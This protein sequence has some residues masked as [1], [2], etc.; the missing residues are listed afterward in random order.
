MTLTTLMKLLQL[1]TLLNLAILSQLFL[2]VG[3]GLFS[4]I[5]FHKWSPIDESPH[6]SYV[7]IISDQKRLPIMGI[8]TDKYDLRYPVLNNQPLS[9]IVGKSSYEAWQPPLYYLLVSPVFV[10]ATH[11]TNKITH[12]IIILRT[13]SL[14][15]YLLSALTFILLIRTLY[16]EEKWR[17]VAF[18]G[19]NVFLIQPMIV[20]NTTVSNCV[21]ELFVMVLIGL[22]YVLHRKV[23]SRKFL[24]AMSMLVGLGLL[25]KLTLAY[26]GI[27]LFIYL[28]FCVSKKQ[29]TLVAAVG[30][31][32]IP[33]LIVAPWIVFNYYHYGLATSG[34]LPTKLLLSITNPTGYNYTYKGDFFPLFN[35][36]LATIFTVD[37]V[38]GTIIQVP[39]I[40]LIVTTFK[41]LLFIFPVFIFLAQRKRFLEL[42]PYYLPLLL[43]ASEQN[44]LTINQNSPVNLGRYLFPALV[45]WFIFLYEAYQN[46]LKERVFGYMA[47][48]IYLANI[49]Y[50]FIFYAFYNYR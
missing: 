10:V 33:L 4:A 2:L 39:I 27:L 3:F 15:I 5:T 31:L 28:V 21:L 41:V 17:L 36:Y 6:F 22:C 37:E 38:R 13:A 35:N 7:E 50:L 47:G 18:F 12:Q 44:I 30:Y 8:D 32:F 20:R 26:T 29:I 43:S 24:Y 48:G 40:D 1:K 19:L 25:T 42:S 11:I 16:S 46:I 34:S 23:G 45:I 9:D 49:C 14:F